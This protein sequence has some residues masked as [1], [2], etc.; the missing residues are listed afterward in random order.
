M[1][2]KQDD[3][4]KILCEYLAA[5]VLPK[6]DKNQPL[7]FLLGFVLESISDQ[8][9]IDFVAEH[10]ALLRVLDVID[11]N[12][13]IDVERLYK[14]SSEVLKKYCSGSFAV[15]GYHVNQNDLDSLR[16]IAS[17]YAC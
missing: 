5:E 11:E 14:V 17:E 7:T 1:K 15:F 12:K 16:L 3:L 2:I 9:V 10:E 4:K 13:D 6:I 8:T